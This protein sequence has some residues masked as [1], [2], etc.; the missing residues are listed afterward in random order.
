MTYPSTL[1]APSIEGFALEPLDP[2]I[3]T[4]MEAGPQ[5]SRRRY[6]V[7]PTGISATWV[8]TLLQFSIFEAWHRHTLADG[9]VAFSCPLAN[10]QGN[11]TWSDVKFA[12]M[13]KA[14][15]LSPNAW[16]V[17]AR[18]EASTRPV[19]SEVELAGYL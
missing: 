1:P 14:Q 15:R 2:V 10:G 17:T 5:R 16:R 3:R 4:D 7:A 11:T 13:W 9:S 8:L 18:L 19:M 6:T 12:D